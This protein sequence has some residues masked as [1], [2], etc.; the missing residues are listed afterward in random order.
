MCGI[1][2]FVTNGEVRQWRADLPKAIAAMHH[3]GP[4][5]NGN[6][7]EANVGLGHARLSI[8]DLTD[9]GHQPMVSHDGRLVM[10]FNGEVYN[11]ADIRREL[12]PL[13]HCF[14]GT[15]DSE[16]ILAAFQQWGKGAVRRFIGM[17]AIA[18]WDKQEKTLTLIRD[19][20]GVKPLYYGWDGTN[21]WFGSELEA[22][23][24]KAW[25]PEIDRDGLS[26]YFRF[27]YIN[28]P[29][30]ILPICIQTSSWALFGIAR[31]R[32]TVDPALLVNPRCG[33][34]AANC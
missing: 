13:G 20:L 19:R 34:V 23:A 33:K 27:G 30:G 16:V 4:D 17:F 2:G 15:G 11:F 24:F 10:V 6:W 3:R 14:A 29:G 25:Q 18:L 21:F 28:A 1:T 31:N 7:L 32:Q 12:E 22:C 26:D 8:L 9:H 5:D